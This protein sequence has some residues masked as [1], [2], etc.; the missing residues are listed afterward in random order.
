MERPVRGKPVFLGV[1]KFNRMLVRLEK[2]PKNKE[3]PMDKFFM[4]IEKLWETGGGEI[5]EWWLG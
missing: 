2:N 3:N 4:T 1:G 5:I